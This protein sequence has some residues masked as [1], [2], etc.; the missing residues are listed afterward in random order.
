MNSRSLFGTVACAILVWEA[1]SAT[2]LSQNDPAADGQ[3]TS[4]RQD[5]LPSYSETAVGQPPSAA[6]DVG[7]FGQP[8]YSPQWTASAEF[9]ILDRLGSVDQ[10]LVSTYPPHSPIVLGSG[11]ERL[12]SNDLDQGF[13]AGPRLD[14]I[15]HGDCGY[16]LEAFVF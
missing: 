1:S 2:V 7:D 14:L 10:P 11:T 4:I 8:G 15:R 5:S 3:L 9:I 13:A 6:C 12:N 16:D